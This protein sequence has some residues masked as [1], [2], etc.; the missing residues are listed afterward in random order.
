MANRGLCLWAL[1]AL[2]VV[3]CWH[4]GLS[5]GVKP[6]SFSGRI[7]SQSPIQREALKRLTKKEKMMRTISRI[8]ENG[9]GQLNNRLMKKQLRRVNRIAQDD[10]WVNDFLSFSRPMPVGG[11]F[12]MPPEVAK[13]A[14][15]EIYG[16]GPDLQNIDL[17]DFEDDDIPIAEEVKDL[18][19]LRRK[20]D[21]SKSPG[22][23]KKTRVGWTSVP[24]VQKYV[25]SVPQEIATGIHGN[26]GGSVSNRGYQDV[27][28]SGGSVR[29]D[30]EDKP[31]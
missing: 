23:S 17:E 8:K 11:E 24:G 31:W 3:P 5:F 19:R 10:A 1:A 27:W 20:V 6:P 16:E 18:E 14:L 12:I 30:Y 28:I 15:E 21:F 2:S 7:R 9:V 4:S 26:V 29:Y 25:G 22:R 13:A